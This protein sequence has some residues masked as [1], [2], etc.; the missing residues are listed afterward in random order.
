M[1][2]STDDATR[3]MLSLPTG[4]FRSTAIDRWLRRS[5]LERTAFPEMEVAVGLSIVTTS[6]PMSANHIAAN[7]AGPIPPRT[8]TRYPD[9]GPGTEHSALSKIRASST[10]GAGRFVP[11]IAGVPRPELREGLEPDG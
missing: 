5:T 4:S 8:R 1:R 2:T 7:G 9:S 3:R 10:T 6:A 11:S